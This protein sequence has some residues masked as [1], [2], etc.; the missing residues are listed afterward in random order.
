[1]SNRSS[2]IKCHSSNG[3]APVYSWTITRIQVMTRPIHF[4]LLGNICETITMIWYGYWL[5][6]SRKFC[7][8]FASRTKDH[9]FLTTPIPVLSR[10]TWKDMQCNFHTAIQ[11]I[12]SYTSH[13]FCK[14]YKKLTFTFK[15][16]ATFFQNISTLTG[17]VVKTSCI[18][19]NGCISTSVWH[20]F[21]ALVNIWN[22][23]EVNYSIH[24]IYWF[25]HLM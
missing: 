17:T 19:T 13:S 5:N 1:M 11:P 7:C 6:S 2:L 18:D 4:L 22:W 23:L 16:K 20:R 8:L 24:Q 9:P 3:G 21:F 10:Q 25:V 14:R 12:A 15:F